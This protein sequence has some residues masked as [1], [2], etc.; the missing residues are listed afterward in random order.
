MTAACAAY[1]A[2]FAPEKDRVPLGKAIK[3]ILFSYF[4]YLVV[5]HYARNYGLERWF[6][7]AFIDKTPYPAEA[8]DH[9]TL[10]RY[11]NVLSPSFLLFASLGRTITMA[12][13]TFV[14]C[15][16][17][18]LRPADGNRVWLH[19]MLLVWACIA[20]RFLMFPAWGDDRY[21]FCYYLPILFA[22][23]E[24]ISAYTSVLWAMLQKHRQQML[25][26]P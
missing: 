20:V 13:F 11:W 15:I 17:Y 16:A 26:I 25:Y 5:S 4:T 3:L 14:A 19:I 8:T 9:L 1:F 10:E 22:G 6:I 21:Y 2:M 23:G 24:L 7:Y 12:A 18:Y